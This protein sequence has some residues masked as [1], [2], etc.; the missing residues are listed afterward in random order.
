MN[1]MKICLPHLLKKIYIQVY[2]VQGGRRG[3][4]YFNEHN[5]YIFAIFI[6][7]NIYT[8]IYSVA[9]NPTSGPT[10]RQWGEGVSHTAH[11]SSVLRE[12]TTGGHY[13]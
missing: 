3:Q 4:V 7:K 12:C 1:T 2:N 5:K 8:S 11:A 10:F 13:L 6:E 9:E